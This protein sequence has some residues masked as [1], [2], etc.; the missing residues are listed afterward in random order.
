MKQIP[1]TAA[2]LALLAGAAASAN[3]LHFENVTATRI[4]QT[5]AEE[6]NNEKA[7]DLGDFDNDGDLDVVI[8]VALSDF[9]A[10]RNKLY[11]NDGGVFTEITSTAIPGFLSARVTRLAFLR[12]YDGDGWLDIY[13]IN[14]QNS[15]VD[16]LFINQHP[17]GVFSGFT[18]VFT[19]PNG[20][21]TGAACGGVSEDFDGDGDYDVFCGNYPNSSQDR[22]LVNGGAANFSDVTGV[23]VPNDFDYTLD[24]AAADMN[25]DSKL[26]LLVANMGDPAYIYYNDLNDAG[27]G[28]G[29]FS[30]A[31]SQQSFG[32]NF[33]E[34]AM[35]PGDFDGDGRMDFYWG[36]ASGDVDQIRRNTGNN[37]SGQA[38]FTTLP[39]TT[40]PPS[41]TAIAS[42][43]ITVDDLNNDGRLDAIVMKED[44]GNERPTILRNTTVN[45][46]ISFVDWTEASA[47]PNGST[48]SGWHCETFDTNADGDL[49]IFLGAFNNDHL[50]EQ[51]PA[52]TFNASSLVGGVV[53]NVFNGSATVVEVTGAE[54]ASD[55]TFLIENVAGGGA[56][57]SAIVNGSSAV[58]FK[59]EVL[60]GG[61]LLGESDRGGAGVEEALQVNNLPAG[62]ITVRISGP[63]VADLNSDTVVDGADLAGL[64]AVWNS[65]GANGGDFNGDDIV[66]GQDLAT[67]LANWGAAN[68]GDY[69][70]ELLARN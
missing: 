50:F 62:T 4:M 53:P 24:I 8:G 67:M 10:K 68:L 2:L 49:D 33:S 56:F 18:E 26:D 58:D 20:G 17:G 19:L 32:T 44:S 69:T 6:P 29:D 65:N 51:M 11:R 70:V 5:V 40:L 15:H 48:H 28:V 22:L 61:N 52:P 35:E 43:K 63:N 14:D 36:N 16:R 27:S 41:V 46:Q 30:Y 54:G 9:G 47:F 39:S 34:N 38:Q 31:G 42:R 12:D 45:G 1:N 3:P 23:M 21:N 7:I 55:N 64:L 13:T 60:Q 59:I 37:G 57:V 25:G 66:N